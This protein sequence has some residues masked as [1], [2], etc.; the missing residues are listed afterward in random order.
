MR[1]LPS[2]RVRRLVLERVAR[3]VQKESLTTF[4][5]LRSSARDARA[6]YLP[7]KSIGQGNVAVLEYRSILGRRCIIDATSRAKGTA[8][9]PRKRSE[10]GFFEPSADPVSGRSTMN[11]D[12]E[13]KLLSELARR[14]HDLDG[15]RSAGV[16]Y[17]YTELK[18]CESCQGVFEQFK[19]LFP[20]IEIVVEFDYPYPLSREH[21]PIEPQ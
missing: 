5:R 6:R 12:A 15:R 8:P 17:L 3:A 9:L 19:E 1:Q 4:T 2:D 7:G 18:P 20:L 14:L 13:Y 16:V 11:T 21:R 10:G